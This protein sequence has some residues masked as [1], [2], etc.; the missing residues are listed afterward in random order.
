M[1]PLATTVDPM[2][3]DGE[4]MSGNITSKLFA[5]GPRKLISLNVW[6]VE[7]VAAPDHVGNIYIDET[8][9]RVDDNPAPV[10]RS[11]PVI[12]IST[13]SEHNGVYDDI[14]IG[15]GYFRVRFVRSSG[16]DD[17]KLYVR[18]SIKE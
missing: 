3:I 13:G 17:D 5:L 18:V 2:L 16:G 12:P 9:E 6:T 15:T 8:S 7:G 10:P 14:E 11:I 1:A 4:L